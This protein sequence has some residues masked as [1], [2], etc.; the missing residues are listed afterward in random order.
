MTDYYIKIFGDPEEQA[1]HERLSSGAECLA[2]NQEVVGSKPTGARTSVPRKP[3]L[4][5]HEDSFSLLFHGESPRLIFIRDTIFNFS[6]IIGM[7]NC[8]YS[9]MS[10]TNLSIGY[11]WS[12]RSMRSM[13]YDLFC[14]VEGP[15]K[16]YAM[17]PT[18]V[19]GHNCRQPVLHHLFF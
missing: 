15:C 8:T 19:S 13:R 5:V 10:L 12:M 4:G 1:S 3:F 16:R 11:H 18:R 9:S 2:H 7:K 6:P 14:V 17:A